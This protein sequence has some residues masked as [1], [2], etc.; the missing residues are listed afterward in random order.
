MASPVPIDAPAFSPTQYSTFLDISKAMGFPVMT[1][2]R[3]ISHIYRRNWLR[4][5]IE[6]VS[7]GAY[8]LFLSGGLRSVALS[9]ENRGIAY[10]ICILWDSR[11]PFM[12]VRSE[13]FVQKHEGV[14]QGLSTIPTDELQYR[15][16]D[17]TGL[18]TGGV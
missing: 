4:T 15:E 17:E 6:A 11:H 10:I 7:F 8:R 5:Y 2:A 14:L 3:G 13:S 9:I 1:I 18:L 12:T 16:I